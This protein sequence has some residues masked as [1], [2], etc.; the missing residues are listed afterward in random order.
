MGRQWHFI[1]A[2]LLFPAV[3]SLD[4][5]RARVSR[6]LLMN[7]ESKTRLDFEAQHI[8]KKRSADGGGDTCNGLQGY[9]TKLL[10]NTHSVSLN[11][12]FQLL[13]CHLTFAFV[14][15]T[16]LAILNYCALIIQRSNNTT[17]LFL[18]YFLF[19]LLLQLFFV[20]LTLSCCYTL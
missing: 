9:N 10:N 11:R 20:I 14:K 18:I 8:I 7:A 1:L 17:V 6:S 2:L 16:R 19:W 15:L 12:L 13:A 4:F 5:G 3:Q